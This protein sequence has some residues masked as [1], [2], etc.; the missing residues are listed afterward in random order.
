[1]T[2]GEKIYTLR[3]QRR[4]SQDDL[5]EKI[6]V[7]RQTVSNWETDKVRPDTDKVILLCGLFDISADYL[8]LDREEAAEATQPEETA[9]VKAPPIPDP[10]KAKRSTWMLL[11]CV[12][13]GIIGFFAVIVSV[14]AMMLTGG[15]GS[16]SL[17]LNWAAGIVIITI[18]ILLVF[19]LFLY[20]Y[21]KNKKQ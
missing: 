2:I 8:L 20:L 1:M 15:G 3:G 17:T 5:A 9:P 21:F 10:K 12:L 11:M 13:L 18:V 6:G 19:A 14:F 4:M 7:S 16:F